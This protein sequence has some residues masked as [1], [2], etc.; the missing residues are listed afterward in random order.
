MVRLVKSLYDVEERW[1]D[2]HQVTDDEKS[3]W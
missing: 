3:Y 1:K 2:T